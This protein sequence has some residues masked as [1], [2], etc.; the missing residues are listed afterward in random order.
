LGEVRNVTIS[1]SGGKWFASI[2]TQ[3]EVEQPLP[4]ATSAIGIDVGIT[5]FATM[6]EL[7]SSRRSTVSEHQQ[8][9]ARYQRMSTRQM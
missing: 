2:Q 1:Q 5:R 6:S 8:R 9:L 3:C 7:A 4:T